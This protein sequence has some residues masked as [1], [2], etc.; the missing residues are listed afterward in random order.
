MSKTIK[1]CYYKNITFDKLLNAHL[2]ASEG[3][4][5][6]KEILLFEMNLETNIIQ[7]MDKLYNG[8]YRFGNYREFKV[9]EPKERIIKSLPYIDRV[10]HQWYIEEFIKPFFY[11]RFITN[12][13]ACLD[14]KGTHKAVLKTQEFMRSMKRKYG[15]FIVLKCDIKKYFYTIDKNI[16]KDILRKNIKDKKLLEFSEIILDD[17]NIKGIP[18]GNY[19][20]Q[21][22][23]NIYLNELDHFVK[24]VLEVKYYI[25][26]MDDFIFLLRNKDEAR[27]ILKEVKKFLEDVLKLELNSKS[28]FFKNEKGIDFCGYRIYETHILLRKRFKKKINKSLK[29]WKRLKKEN[30]FYKK[31]FL[32]AL[33]SY[34][35]HASHAN[36]Y[37]Y[38][39]KIDNKIINLE[40]N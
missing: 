31:K 16:L 30:R 8:T 20:S 18:I 21:Y 1:N 10:V 3:K 35:G 5:S 12:S 7:I 40:I 17:G 34:K 14:N 37:N 19:T 15:S 33:N 25:R 39:K 13:Y 9:Y 6:K 2:R 36:S 28:T 29:L 4:K 32:L 23:A 24:E 22:F 26:Y 38:I 27:K 11:P